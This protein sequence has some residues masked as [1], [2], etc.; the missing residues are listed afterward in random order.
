MAGIPGLCIGAAGPRRPCRAKLF[1]RSSRPSPS[2]SSSLPSL[3]WSDASLPTQLS[4]CLSAFEVM[5]PYAYFD[6]VALGKSVEVPELRDIRLV[7]DVI[8]ARERTVQAVKS[9]L[10]SAR[11][12]RGT[13]ARCQQ[14]SPTRRASSCRSCSR[15]CGRRPHTSSSW[16]SSGAAGACRWRLAAAGR[17]FRSS[18][19]AWA[20]TT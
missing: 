15:D 18:S 19:C 1:R 3:N 10:A 20:A 9:L 13:R 11:Y 17:P 8:D 7:F 12:I 5:S 14:S 4:R 16:S 2:K 6:A